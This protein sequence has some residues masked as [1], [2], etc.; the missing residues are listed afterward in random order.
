MDAQP[1]EPPRCPRS[2]VL[3]DHSGSF[4]DWKTVGEE[5]CENTHRWDQVTDGGSRDGGEGTNPKTARP[6]LHSLN[7]HFVGAYYVLCTGERT[8]SPTPW[9]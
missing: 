7:T 6:L 9:G 8:Q 2:V 4:M 3:K 1:T 5:T